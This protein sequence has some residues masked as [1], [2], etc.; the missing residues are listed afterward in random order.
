MFG[1]NSRADVSLKKEKT[2]STPKQSPLSFSPGIYVFSPSFPSSSE[3]GLFAPFY[4]R[5]REPSPQPQVCRRG[6]HLF[7]Q[8]TLLSPLEL[9]HKHPQ[10]KKSQ[11]IP[12]RLREQRFSPFNAT[13]HLQVA[14]E[15]T[16]ISLAVWSTPTKHPRVKWPE[17]A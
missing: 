4:Q 3:C 10:I 8:S 6:L 7:R 13:H 2:C 14:R 1:A 16:L 15:R 5:A 9:H 17:L 12:S 11:Y